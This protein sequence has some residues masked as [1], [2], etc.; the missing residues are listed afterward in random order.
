MKT[1][2]AKWGNSLAVRLPRAAAEEAKLR[3]GDQVQVVARRGRL[4]VRPVRRKLS[5]KELVA[6]IT[7]ENRPDATDWGA[8]VGR[9]TW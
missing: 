1:L 4:E 3:E 6:G 2:V 5:L 8:P 7:R 9:E